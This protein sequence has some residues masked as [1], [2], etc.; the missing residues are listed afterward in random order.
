MSNYALYIFPLTIYIIV[1]FRKCFSL[2]HVSNRIWFVS[3]VILD[4]QGT[5][6]TEAMSFGPEFSEQKTLAAGSGYNEEAWSS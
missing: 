6:C 4:Y 2:L 5:G 1:V 3:F